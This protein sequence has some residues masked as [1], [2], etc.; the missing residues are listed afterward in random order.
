MVGKLTYLL[1]SGGAAEVENL[2]FKLREENN[3]LLNQLKVV[4]DNLSELKEVIRTLESEKSTLISTIRI[5]Q[6]NNLKLCREEICDFTTAGPST[7]K[8]VTPSEAV[9]Q[10]NFSVVSPA[11]KINQNGKNKNKKGKATEKIKFRNLAQI[12]HCLKQTAH[13]L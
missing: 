12:L 2:N 1:R 9:K 4:N 5:L 10:K 13:D 8:A 11:K 6:R 3:L 7:T